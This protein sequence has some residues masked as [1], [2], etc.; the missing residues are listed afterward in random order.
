MKTVTIITI[1]VVIIVIILI[2]MVL[3]KSCVSHFR[4]IGNLN[5]RDTNS[6]DDFSYANINDPYNK[7]FVLNNLISP[8]KCQEIMQFANGKLFDSQV[9][10]GTDKNIRN[11]QQMWIPK[12]NPM[13]KPIFENICRQF[14]V[15]FDNAEDLQVVRY[16]PNQYYNEHHDSCCDSSKQCSEFI[17]RGGQRI[18]TVLIYL[19]NEFS[20]GYTYFPNL[21]QKFKPKTGDALVF[22]PLANNSNKCHPYS[23]HAGMPVTSGEKWIANLWFRER[24]FS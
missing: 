5:S 10:S 22:Y 4:N 2:I 15:P 24:K 16:L 19:N 14:N 11:S 12:N 8:T 1:I 6:K 13:V 20:D 18:L 17:E 3:S 9:L 23:L 21:N 7:P